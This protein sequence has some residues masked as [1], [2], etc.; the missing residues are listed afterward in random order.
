MS[1]NTFFSTSL[2]NIEKRVIYAEKKCYRKIRI[3]TLKWV[4]SAI[5]EKRNIVAKKNVFYGYL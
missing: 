5:L 3:K 4:V 2:K 1:E